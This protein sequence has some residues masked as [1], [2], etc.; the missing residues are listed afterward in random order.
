MSQA[1]HG[2]LYLLLSDRL[3]ASLLGDLQIDYLIGKRTRHMTRYVNIGI[4]LNQVLR[5]LL[6]RLQVVVGSAGPLR[7][8]RHLP[9]RLALGGDLENALR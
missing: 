9:G 7:G 8:T 1:L 4:V 6:D 5:L 3:A 2:S